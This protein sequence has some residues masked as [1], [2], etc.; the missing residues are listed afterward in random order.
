M[1]SWRKFR[2]LPPQERRVFLAVLVLLP[3]V[4]VGLR[5]LGLR[6]VLALLDHRSSPGREPGNIAGSRDA[7]TPLRAVAR[8]E[9]QGSACDPGTPPR[10]ADAI[11]AGRAYRTTR[12]VTAAA[13]FAGGTCLAR[14]IV[15]VALLRRR[16][17]PAELR[18]GVRKGDR[19][20]EAHAWVVAAET[21]LNDEPDV[22]QRFA[23]FDHNFA[24]ARVDWR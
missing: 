1:N 21:I 8:P 19:G 7:D 2:R 13:R 17:I 16:G 4:R 6:R 14:S 18:I 22:T 20:F 24:L 9:A 10:A 3:A 5:T 23:A 12:L 15:L 11:D